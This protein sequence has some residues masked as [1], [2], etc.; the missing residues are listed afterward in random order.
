MN[1]IKEDKKKLL[2]ILEELEEEYMAGNISDEKYKFLSKE[3][4]DKLSNISAVDKIRSMQGKG[5]AEK[6]L[7]NFS[8]KSMAERSKKEDEQLVDK[9]VTNSSKEKQKSTGSNKGMYVGIA[10]VCICVAFVAGIGF[11][12]FNLDS[13]STPISASVTINE[14]A[15]PDVISNITKNKTNID[16][17]SNNNR[18]SDSDSN[19]NSDN[20]EDSNTDSN[21][22]NNNNNQNNKPDTS[23]NTRPQQQSNTRN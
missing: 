9:Y 2:K 5:M 7:S 14:T 13:S 23:T 4:N 20:D 1:I 16:S 12:I 10:I 15:F 22:N 3:Y 8:K 19:S 18:N 17:N 6:P 11:G 21:N